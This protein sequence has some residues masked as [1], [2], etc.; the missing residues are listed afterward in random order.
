MTTARSEPVTVTVTETEAASVRACAT[1][2]DEGRAVGS[3][4]HFDLEC[5]TD[6]PGAA[7]RIMHAKSGTLKYGRVSVAIDGEGHIVVADTNN[8][9]VQVLRRDGTHVRTIGC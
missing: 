7:L 1:V 2:A 5:S 6:G 8:H 3:R 9:R 4:V